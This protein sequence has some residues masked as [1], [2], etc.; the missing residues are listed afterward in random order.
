[1][2]AG[3]RILL[4]VAGGIAAYKSLDLIRRLRERGAAVRCILTA[5]GA[6]F[7]TPLSLA[8]LSGDK[9]YGEPHPDDVMY[10]RKVYQA[11]SIRLQTLADRGI[12]RFVYAYD[13]GDNWQHDVIIEG[14]RDGAADIDYPAFVDGARLGPPEDVGGAYGF[15]DFPESVLDPAHEEHARMLEWYGSPF[16]PE[17]I[18]Q[19]SSGLDDVLDGIEDAA[20]AMVAYKL[21][22]IPPP[23]LALCQIVYECSGAL[24]LAFQALEKDDPI[25]AHCIEINRLED[26]ADTILRTAISDLF[27][28]ETNPINL[29]KSKE[30]F[31]FLEATTDRCEDVADTLQAVVVKNS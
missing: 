14:L 30:V 21:E 13:F 4:I 27:A 12:G 18:H 5:A 2:L 28:H 19:I 3:K 10:D 11:K 23:V 20:Y 16:D 15:M 24:R 1:M 29:I 8:A 31:E 7:V 9:V 22:P 25:L 26:S 17:D 6:K